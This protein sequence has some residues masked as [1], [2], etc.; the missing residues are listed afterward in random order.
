LYRNDQERAATPPP[1]RSSTG[2]KQSETKQGEIGDKAK[3]WPLTISYL[4]EQPAGKGGQGEEEIGC[5]R[6]PGKRPTT[7]LRLSRLGS[8]HDAPIGLRGRQ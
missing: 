1:Q 4:V 2:R 6:P 7:W 5:A 8:A 3:V